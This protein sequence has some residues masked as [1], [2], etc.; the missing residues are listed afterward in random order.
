MFT[1]VILCNGSLIAMLLTVGIVRA[2]AVIAGGQ[3][4]VPLILLVVPVTILRG[5]QAAEL[6]VR[7]S[8]QTRI[9][10]A[11]NPLVY[12][13]VR[14]CTHISAYPFFE[15]LG[16][17]PSRIMRPQLACRVQKHEPSKTG[18]HI[19]TQTK[20][21]AHTWVRSVPRRLYCAA[22]NEDPEFGLRRSCMTFWTSDE[23]HHILEQSLNYPG[24]IS[25]Y[26]SVPSIL[27]I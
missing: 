19:C 24:A 4:M 16:I 3:I 8:L 25:E 2:K 9:F 18:P 10:S 13:H 6:R 17:I 1:R 15:N 21:W 12:M 27:S 14:Q 20:V 7:M 22:H 26:S 11:V 23:T 5:R